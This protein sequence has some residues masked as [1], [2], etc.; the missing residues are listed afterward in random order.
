MSTGSAIKYIAD[1]VDIT[2]V[3]YSAPTGLYTVHTVY[4]IF[5]GMYWSGAVFPYNLRYIVGFWLVEMAISTNQ[6]P[7]IYRNLYDNTASDLTDLSKHK[8]GVELF[9]YNIF[10]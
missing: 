10:Q 2:N 4:A 9:Y 6:K 8:V 1:P 7:T 5:D 3:H